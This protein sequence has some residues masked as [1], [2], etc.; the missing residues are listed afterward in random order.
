MSDPRIIK[1]KR[2]IRAALIA[3]LDEVAYDDITI[4]RIC[5]AALVSRPTFYAHYD[6]IQ[7]ILVEHVSD[8]YEKKI[9]KY[10]DDLDYTESKVAIVEGYFKLIMEIKKEVNL[11]YKNNLEG[12]FFKQN[13][14][15]VKRMLAAL[16]SPTVD[17]LRKNEQD[18]EVYV[19]A[20]CGLFYAQTNRLIENDWNLD[21]PTLVKQTCDAAGSVVHI[22]LN[23]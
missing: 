10:L 6:S 17:E 16:E 7:Q 2:D 12:V 4:K 21:I 22:F 9:S 13:R 8:L 23:R 11:L 14:L 3:L 5:E 1:T 18:L 20:V 15:L 19:D